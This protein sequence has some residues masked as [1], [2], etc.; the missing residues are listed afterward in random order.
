MVSIFGDI[1]ERS[2]AH[3]GLTISNVANPLAAQIHDG[4][5]FVAMSRKVATFAVSLN[6][7]PAAEIE[8]TRAFLRR[9]VD[10]LILTAVADDQS[11]LQL[12]IDRGTAVVFVERE[13]TG[14]RADTVKVNDIRS[15]ATAVGHLADIG[16]RRIAHLGDRA[17]IQTGTRT[18]G[19]LP[20]R[21]GGAWSARRRDHPRHLR[22]TRRLRG[23]VPTPRVSRSAHRD[24]L[25][26]EPHDRRGPEAL[27]DLGL[28]HQV[29]LMGFDG[30]PMSDLL[31]PPVTTS[32]VSDAW[33][34]NGSSNVSAGHFRTPHDLRTH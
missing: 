6:E 16:H 5:E 15:A 19:G 12:A 10:R 26:A 24:S 22:R 23:S 2:H 29:A 31:D 28:C 3:D 27:R 9:R 8:H 25:G 4:V 7:E 34:Q 33:P 30:F 13:P 1:S 32:A 17:R 21:H 20:S 11:Y 18:Q 14:L